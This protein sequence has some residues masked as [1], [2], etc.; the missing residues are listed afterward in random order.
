MTEYL[1]FAGVL[2][3]N[4]SVLPQVVRIIRL[5]DSR[6]ISILNVLMAIVGFSILYSKA[7]YDSSRFFMFNYGVSLVL[8]LLFL[9]VTLK[10]RG[11]FRSR[12][13]SVGKML[14]EAFPYLPVGNKGVVG[15]EQEFLDGHSFFPRMTTCLRCG[16]NKEEIIQQKVTC[17]GR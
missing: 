1:W 6:D 7:T 13:K 4:F 2:I 3:L 16:R 17:G 10:Y 15:P 14:A 12:K 8:E 9:L 5:Q 11:F